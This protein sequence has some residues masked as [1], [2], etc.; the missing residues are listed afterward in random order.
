MVEHPGGVTASRVQIAAP[1]KI[2]YFYTVNYVS[3]KRQRTLMV[4]RNY[5]IFFLQIRVINVFSLNY[6]NIYFC[7]YFNNVD[8]LLLQAGVQHGVLQNYFAPVNVSMS[9][10]YIHIDIHCPKNTASR[11]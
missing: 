4:Y 7:K 10:S 3:W 6:K 9:M 8:A 1:C 11:Y 5:Y 2:L